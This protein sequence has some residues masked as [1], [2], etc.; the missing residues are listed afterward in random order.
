MNSISLLTAEDLAVAFQIEQSCHRYPWSEKTF[1][2][3]QGER[4]FN[5]KL[6][7]D[8]KTLVGF[9]ITQVIADEAVLFNIAICP[10][11]QR[12]GYGRLLLE[13]LI[14]QLKA[15]A[16][17][18]LWLEVRVSNKGAIALYE[19]VGF[20]Q[21]SLRPDYYPRDSGREDAMIMALVLA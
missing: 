5:L 4:Y 18:T 8:E 12:R 15:R 1:F 3:N 13:Y 14:G 17:M 7:F 16:V 11:Q 6:T 20:N 10:E 21:I 19:Q 2:S 9:A